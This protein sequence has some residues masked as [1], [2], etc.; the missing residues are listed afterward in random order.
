[1]TIEFHPSQ[2][3]SLSNACRASQLQSW[4]CAITAMLLIGI[5]ASTRN[6]T[7]KLLASG[8]T[9]AAVA[10]SQPSRRT[11]RKLRGMVRDGEDL[12]AAAYQQ[13]LW[14]ALKPRQ[15]IEATIVEPEPEV[16]LLPI[17]SL[18]AYPSILIYGGQGSGK[19]SLAAYLLQKRKEA[20]HAITVLDPHA[21]H[22]QWDGLRVVGAGMQHGEIDSEITA[23]I[24][25]VEA[26]YTEHREKPTQFNPSTIFVDE[27]TNLASRCKN[28]GELF[29]SGVSDLRKINQHLL[30][31]SHARTLAGLGDARGMAKTRDNGLLE[32]F[33][34]VD[35]D[36]VTGKAKPA[37][38]GTIKYPGKEPM[39]IRLEPWMKG[40]MDF[41][42]IQP[43]IADSPI[44]NL[45]ET[46]TPLERLEALIQMETISP[47][48]PKDE[49]LDQLTEAISLD[50]MPEDCRIILKFSR[51]KEWFSAR[52]LK[53][54]RRQFRDKSTDELKHLLLLLNQAEWLECQHDDNTPKFRLISGLGELVDDWG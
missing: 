38:T 46:A 50:E 23:F 13:Y 40:G 6:M 12:S 35:I 27:F 24:K 5:T 3:D 16:P 33:L 36:L 39:P 43:A 53:R 31:V 51:D 44:S 8:G 37:M 54:N 17:D 21:G 30:I 20:G 10:I 9:L 1:M 45:P 7:Y 19:T 32:V 22:A 42:R 14:E 26:S 49:L 48:M 11:W 25:R 2:Y 4:A 28:A 29:K 18:I 47:E 34:E 41:S 52:D 15:M